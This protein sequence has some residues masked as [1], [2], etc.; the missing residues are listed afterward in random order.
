[1]KPTFIQ[2]STPSAISAPSSPR[3]HSLSHHTLRNNRTSLRRL[4]RNEDQVL[5]SQ[6]III[7]LF[8]EEVQE[9]DCRVLNRIW[10]GIPE[11]INS[12]PLRDSAERKTGGPQSRQEIMSPMEQVSVLDVVDDRGIIT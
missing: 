1:M 8:H 4:L 7:I 3:D 9:L 2:H 6:L 12:F 11:H 5:P 10:V